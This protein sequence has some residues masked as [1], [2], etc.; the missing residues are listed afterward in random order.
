MTMK[1]RWKSSGATIAI[2]A[3]VN[4]VA[5]ASTPTLTLATSTGTVGAQNASVLANQS[6]LSV[7]EK[8]HYLRKNIKYVF[9]LFQEN[10][11]FDHYFGTYPGANG[12]Y[13]TFPGA[14]T[15]NPMQQPAN[16]TQS[17]SQTIQNTDGSYGTQTPFLMPRQINDTNGNP[18]QIY[19]EDSLSV[20]HSH[21]GMV[22]SVH[23]DVATRSITKNDAYVL[24]QEGPDLFGRCLH[25]DH[26]R[27][28]G[29]RAG[30]QQAFAG[31][32]AGWRADGGAH[33]L[34]H[35]SVPVAVCRPFRA[36]G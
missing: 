15:T 9:V 12:L 17:F 2:L 18:V 27:D 23:A 20:D 1:Q 13:S 19:P 33:G 4:N 5:F 22:D 3:M 34:R 31:D 7:D 36:A 8:L 11:S 35:R 14:D 26:D 32:Q 25:R 24:D 29:R 16:M 28:Q 6:K 10:R 30:D 21:V